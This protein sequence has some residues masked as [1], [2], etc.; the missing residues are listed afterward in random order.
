MLKFISTLSLVLMLLP[1]WRLVP[2]PFPD[3][4]LA[5]VIGIGMGIAVMPD[6]AICGHEFFMSSRHVLEQFN[7]TSRSLELSIDST[8]K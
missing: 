8:I 6:D 3:W 5:S 4:W 2:G 7:V 1:N